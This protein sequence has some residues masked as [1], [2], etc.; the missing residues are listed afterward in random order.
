MWIFDCVEV[1][2]SK[3]RVI[4]ESSLPGVTVVGVWPVGIILKLE[5]WPYPETA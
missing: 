2:A 5:E 4:Q 3:P 1:G